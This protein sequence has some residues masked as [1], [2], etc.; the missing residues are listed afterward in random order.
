MLIVCV[1]AKILFMVLHIF[2]FKFL[3]SKFYFI[4]ILLNITEVFNDLKFYNN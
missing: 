4:F 2:Y 3:G 1:V